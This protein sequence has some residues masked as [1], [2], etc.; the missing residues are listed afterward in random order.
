MIKRDLKTEKDFL[1]AI[2]E[3]EI[4]DSAEGDMEEDSGFI[5][6]VRGIA[7]RARG[8]GDESSGGGGGADESF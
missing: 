1:S 4:D 7:G 3:L 6:E 5:D 2:Q 8:S